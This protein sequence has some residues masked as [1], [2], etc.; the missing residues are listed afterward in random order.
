MKE[1]KKLSLIF[2]T[3]VFGFLIYHKWLPIVGATL[4]TLFLLE[5]VFSVIKI[6]KI[7][8]GISFIVTFLSIFAIIQ[9]AIYI[10][11]NFDI[12]FSMNLDQLKPMFSYLKIPVPSD[13]DINYILKISLEYLKSHL[14]ILSTIGSN[15]LQILIGMIFGLLFF[16]Y[17]ISSHKEE[18]NKWGLFVKSTTDYLHVLFNSFQTIM[19]LQVVVAIMNTISL[20][21]LSFIISYLLTGNFLPY[22]YILLPLAFIFSLIPVIGNIII[23]LLIFVIAINISIIFTI[24]SIIYFFIVHKI[25]LITIAKLLGTKSSIPFLFIALSMLIGELIFNSML[26]VL[27]GITMLLTFKDI[28]SK[29]N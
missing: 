20:A 4:F 17:D 3:I 6:K 15:S 23:N 27:F 22:W 13:F 9:F 16:C 29:N 24:V 5:T 8:L 1:E 26:G 2:L 21:I 18:E 25:E 28:M 10:G 7:A 12:L 19:K 11:K 14:N